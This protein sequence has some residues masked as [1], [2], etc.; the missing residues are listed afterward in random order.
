ME[1]LINCPV[2]NSTSFSPFLSCVDHTVSRE[3]FNVVQCNLCG[4]K[5][6]N[7]RPEEDK[8]GPYYNSDEYVSQGTEAQRVFLER[9]AA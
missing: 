8:L 6:T 9:L 5:F 3:T 4:F 2:C 1:A 7:P